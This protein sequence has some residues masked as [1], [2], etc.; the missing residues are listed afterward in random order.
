[1]SEETADKNRGT[2]KADHD[3]NRQHDHR[4]AQCQP[5]DHHDESD[6]DGENVSE[7]AFSRFDPTMVPDVRVYHVNLR[8]WWS[9]VYARVEYQ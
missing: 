6:D 5:D 4:H 7:Q 1:M 8:F 9:K 2:G 3:A